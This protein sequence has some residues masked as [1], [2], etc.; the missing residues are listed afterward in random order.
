MIHARHTLLLIESILLSTQHVFENGLAPMPTSTSEL[1]PANRQWIDLP[2]L[3]DP[4][5]L[6]TDNNGYSMLLIRKPG[7]VFNVNTWVKTGSIHE[8]AQNS[9]VSH[10]LEHLMFKGTKRF[11]P[12]EFDRAME[13]MGAIINAA[14]WKDF[15]FYYV[16]GPNDEAKENFVKALDMHSDMLLHSTLPDSEIGPPYDPEDPDYDGEKRERSVVIEEIGMREDQP[17][18]KVYNAVNKMMYPEGHPYQRD[19]IGTRQIVG[20][21]PRHEIERY[22]KTWYAPDSMT[23]VVVG[24][25]EPDWLES[26]LRHHFDFEHMADAKM[27]QSD[28]D[29][30]LDGVT[31][32]TVVQKGDTETA[33]FL[34]GYHGPSPKDLEASIALDIVSFVLGESRSARLVQSLIEKQEEP[35]FNILSTGQNTFKLGNVMFLQGNYN[36]VGPA[37]D[38]NHALGLAQAEIDDFLNKTPITDDE[39]KRAVKKLKADFAETVETAAGMAETLGEC[40]TVTGNTDGYLRYIETLEKLTASRVQEIARKYLAKDKGFH[41]VLVP[42]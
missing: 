23:T 39:C 30:S 16:T 22:Y 27:K 24:D 7:E 9:G 34:S 2:Y 18:T 4:A 10:F 38:H 6:I 33:F 29:W 21:I 32:G 40:I 1:T 37:E 42:A 28:Y 35:V 25:F 5:Q 12:G 17:W 19:V 8:D 13:G 31:P 26:K 3:K 14:T 41:A 20:T 11:Q 15:T 36:P